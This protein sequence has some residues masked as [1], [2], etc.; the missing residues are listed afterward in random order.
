MKN[1]L[2]LPRWLRR[3]QDRR[4]LMSMDDRMLADVGISRSQIDLY[5]SGARGR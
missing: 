4:I 2:N 1:A 3:R 5:L